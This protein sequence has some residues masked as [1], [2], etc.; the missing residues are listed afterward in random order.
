MAYIRHRMLW[1]L[2]QPA[3]TSQCLPVELLVLHWSLSKR[4]A[5]CFSWN[6]HWSQP[7][8]R[9]R[10]AFVHQ[11]WM[12]G[13][14]PAAAR[15]RVAAAATGHQRLPSV[16]VRCACSRPGRAPLACQRV[17]SQCNE[18]LTSSACASANT[19]DLRSNRSWSSPWTVS[20]QSHR[21]ELW[22][23]FLGTASSWTPTLS[24]PLLHWA[25]G[26]TCAR[27]NRG[28]EHSGEPIAKIL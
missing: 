6:V 20:K 26:D 8:S 27:S 23:T 24:A 9:S 19:C 7:S 4:R 17:T 13:L 25:S 5:L 12:L 3:V 1:N 16:R 10:P 18:R 11:V 21:H 2:F 28:G 14:R 22:R 15:H